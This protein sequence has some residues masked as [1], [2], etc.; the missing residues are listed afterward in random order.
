MTCLI[1]VYVCP[2]QTKAASDLLEPRC[3]AKTG[4]SK[5]VN[6]PSNLQVSYEFVL[7]VPSSLKKRLSRVSTSVNETRFAQVSG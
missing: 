5:G 4:S 3:P 1:N 2:Y 6:V 7:P